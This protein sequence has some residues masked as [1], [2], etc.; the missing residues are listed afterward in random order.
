MTQLQPAFYTSAVRYNGSFTAIYYAFNIKKLCV[1][2]SWPFE[3]PSAD[4]LTLST[5]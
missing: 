5:V 3:Q 1:F 4:T 2:Q